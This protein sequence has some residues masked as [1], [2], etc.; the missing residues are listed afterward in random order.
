M[1]RDFQPAASFRFYL[2]PQIDKELVLMAL[3][4]LVMKVLRLPLRSARAAG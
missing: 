2:P 4:R 3:R 1:D